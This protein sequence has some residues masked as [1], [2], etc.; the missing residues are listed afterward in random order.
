[1]THD[2]G[3]IVASLIGALVL[4][5]IVELMNVNRSLGTERHKLDLT[6]ADDL[7]ES[8]IALRTG[9]PIPA[10]RRRVVASRIRL[11]VL[12]RKTARRRLDALYW[13]WGITIAVEGGILQAIVE[14]AAMGNGGPAP[15]RALLITAGTTF[16]MLMTIL[17]AGLRIR[18]RDTLTT[19]EERVELADRM[20]L[21]PTEMR[22]LLRSWGRHTG[23]DW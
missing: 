6:F 4:V 20:G 15:L 17:N 1:M 19:W 22:S 3:A 23:H 13:F 5:G 18:W 14:W 7:K 12:L 8:A 21:P 10:P 11:Y 2:Y 16:A 9:V